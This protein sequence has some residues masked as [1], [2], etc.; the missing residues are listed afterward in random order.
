LRT[1]P[2]SLASLV[3]IIAVLVA[4]LGPAACG[5]DDGGN[6]EDAVR[7]TVNRF[8]DATNDERF[9]TI[10]SLLAESEARSIE[11]QGGG[12]CAQ[13]L[14]GLPRSTA[15]VRLRIDEVRIS[16]DR[17]AVDATA[18]TEDGTRQPQTLRLVEEDGDWKIA[19]VGG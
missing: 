7:E 3:V 18:I 5:G 8:I 10:C 11:S 9:R 17:A 1:L 15:D 19:S 4:A 13:V 16:D 2:R 6:D 12:P 14:E